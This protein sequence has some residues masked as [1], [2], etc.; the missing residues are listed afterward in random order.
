MKQSTA[1]VPA[2]LTAL[3][4]GLALS[5]C[6][7]PP[8]EVPG[9]MDNGA[10][11]PS[12][13]PTRSIE[14][15][16]NELATGSTQHDL[17]AG[18][19]SLTVD[20]FSTLSMDQWTASANKPLSLSFSAALGT[21]DGQKVYLSEVSM[22]AAVTGPDGPLPAPTAIVDRATINPGYLVKAPYSYSQTFILPEL[23]P[24]ASSVTLTLKYELLLQ[25]TP[26]SAEFAKQTA[27]DSLTIAIAPE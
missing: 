14:T 20:Y 22:V 27:A 15:I 2:A 25:T 18:D 9:A 8:W 19:I 17:T 10:P 13:S 4:I 12:L 16:V 21:D 23:D 26:T 3:F 24:E 6:G 11:S 5:G 7:V 1:I